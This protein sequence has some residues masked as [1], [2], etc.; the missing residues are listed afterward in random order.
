MLTSLPCAV[1]D[2]AIECWGGGKRETY[3]IS[4]TNRFVCCGADTTSFVRCSSSHRHLQMPS[5]WLLSQLQ[6]YPSYR[7]LWI[8]F[9]PDERE[10]ITK[11]GGGWKRI[12]DIPLQ[13]IS[14]DLRSFWRASPLPHT[15][16]IPACVGIQPSR[17]TLSQSHL[18]V[19]FVLLCSSLCR[20]PTKTGQI[21]CFIVFS[22]HCLLVCSVTACVNIQPSSWTLSSYSFI[23]ALFLLSDQNWWEWHYL[24]SEQSGNLRNLEVAQHRCAVSR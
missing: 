23:S 5:V 15:G 6:W 17:S 8:I 22:S 20:Y 16:R 12:T 7:P 21:Y 10:E 1:C 14:N 9:L 11:S 4:D 3:K 13:Y 2:Q 24:C 19:S 18:F